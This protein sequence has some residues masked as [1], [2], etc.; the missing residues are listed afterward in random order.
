MV[1]DLEEVGEAEQ[2][3]KGDKS[4]GGEKAVDYDEPMPRRSKRATSF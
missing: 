2:T 3:S 1:E 4:K